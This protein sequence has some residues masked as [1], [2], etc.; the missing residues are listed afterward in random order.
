MNNNRDIG[1]RLCKG[2]FYLRRVVSDKTLIK[3]LGTDSWFKSY[4]QHDMTQLASP[5]PIIVICFEENDSFGP[6]GD[7]IDL[8]FKESLLL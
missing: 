4:Y 8:S 5:F 3:L 7:S 6:L 1:R 2:L